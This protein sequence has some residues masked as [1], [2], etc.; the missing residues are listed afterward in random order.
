MAL[1]DGKRDARRGPPHCFCAH[2]PIQRLFTWLCDSSRDCLIAWPGVWRGVDL[3]EQMLHDR[4]IRGDPGIVEQSRG[5]RDPI[6]PIVILKREWLALEHFPEE[7]PHRRRLLEPPARAGLIT[8]VTL[9]GHLLAEG[10]GHS[11]FFTEFTVE[12]FIQGLSWFKFSAG[13]LPHARD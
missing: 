3:S 13:E 2:L 10:D 6:H 8:F 9:R 1:R 11:K 5:Q 12:P 7:E 4:T